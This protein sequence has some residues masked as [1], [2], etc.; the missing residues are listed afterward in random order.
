M[1]AIVSRPCILPSAI[2]T[3]IP[4][5]HAFKN[6]N[7]LHRLARFYVTIRPSLHGLHEPNPVKLGNYLSEPPI[8]KLDP[9]L[10]R[11]HGA[12]Q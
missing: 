10:H 9:H 6:K 8:S 5:A 11:H 3:D 1:I 4:S 12:W 2:E 7:S